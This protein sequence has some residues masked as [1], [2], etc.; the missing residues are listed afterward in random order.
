[1]ETKGLPVIEAVIG[2][3]AVIEPK[4]L[5]YQPTRYPSIL[6]QRLSKEDVKIADQPLRLLEV[7]KVNTFFRRDVSRKYCLHNHIPR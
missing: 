7:M 3:A 5:A 2:F 4:T 6:Y 1:L